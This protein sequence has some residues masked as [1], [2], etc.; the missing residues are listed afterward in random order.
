MQMLKSILC[1]TV[2]V[3]A[4]CATG[5]QKYADDYYDQG[6]VFFER[7]EYTRAVESFD[8][9]LELEPNSKDSYKVYYNRGNAYLKN[10]QYEQ[11]IY[12]FTKALERTPPNKKQ[13]R[14]FILESRG[15]ARQKNSQI[16][17][18]IEDY[19]AAIDIKLVPRQKNIHYVYHNRGWSWITKERYNDAI[20]DFDMA[21]KHDA[22]FAPAYYGRAT[23]L[24][25]KDDYQRAA[26]DAK[27]A[28]K[29]DP[30]NKAYDDLL[31]DIRT[32]LNNP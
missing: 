17:A 24:Y 22:E 12:D 31:F 32:A 13:M 16:D 26:I 5:S 29:R 6:L 25:R 28:L 23:A 19:S 20:N 1:L 21:L 9:V 2:L 8:K 4:S 7:M 18:S 3:V 14:Y 30:G 11:A 27:D 15:N 10:R